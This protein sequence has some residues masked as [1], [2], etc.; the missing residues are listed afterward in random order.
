MLRPAAIL[1]GESL[2]DMLKRGVESLWRLS[3][4]STFRSLIGC[5]EDLRSVLFLGGVATTA[6][7]LL[8]E[9]GRLFAT[10]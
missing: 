3:V 1:V 2:I 4:I 5:T 7:A 10:L 6:V 9:S 8:K